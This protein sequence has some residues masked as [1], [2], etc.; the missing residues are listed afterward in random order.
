MNLKNKKLFSRKKNKIEVDSPVLI[1]EKLKKKYIKELKLD[2]RKVKDFIKSKHNP[3]T[4]KVDISASLM[5]KT[6][7]YAKASN[8][9]MENLSL[10]LATKYENFFRPMTQ[11]LSSSNIK[12]LSKTYISM[13]LF[14]TILMFPVSL[15]GLFILTHNIFISFFLSL[16][17][18][19]LT[20]GLGYIYPLIIVNDRKN[21]INQELVFASVHMAAIA[22]SGAQPINIFQLLVDSNEYEELGEELKRVLN[23]VRVFGYNLTNALKTVA[24]TT[25][26]PDLKELFYGITSTIETGGDITQYLNDK[27]DDSLTKYGFSQK[28]HLETIATYSEV[29]TGFLIAGPLLFIVTFAILEKISPMVAG[30]PIA[31]LATLGTFVLLPLLNVL[32]ILLLET[33]RSEV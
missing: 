6:N 2:H 16:V 11:A 4:S 9:F 30:M 1:N 10:R 25:P 17:I 15:A 29:Y 27:A 18:T 21:K 8:F 5:Y 3:K 33:S 20:F 22:G 24:A 13:I 32:F 7:I 19:G 31:T 23:Y 14:S 28:K 26:S 12:I